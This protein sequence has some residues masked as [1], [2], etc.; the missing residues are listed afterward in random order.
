MQFI[1]LK[2]QYS[3]LKADID[4]R[5]HAVLDHGSYIMGPE[6]TKLE[7]EL[8][9]YV[10]VK[11]CL[12]CANGTDALLLALMAYGVKP[13][14]GIITTPFTF[15]ATAEVIALLGAVPIFVDIDP[16]TYNIN[17]DALQE[18]IT[19]VQSGRNLHNK[20]AFTGEL[21]G[22]IPV[23]LF[24]IPADYAKINSIAKTNGLFVLEDAAQS[25]GAT[26][27]GKKAGLLSEI[28]ATSFFPAKPLGCYGDGGAVFTDNEEIIA[29]MRSLRIHGQGPD[30]YTNIRI[31]INGRMDTIQ[32]AIVLS[33]LSIF[34]IELASRQQVAMRYNQI[35]SAYVETPTVPDGST[36][37][38][39]QYSVQSD[40]RTEVMSALSQQGI[41]TAIYYPTPL[42]LQ[43]AFEYCGYE[44]NSFPVSEKASQRIFSLP[45]HPYLT[46]EEQKHIAKVFA[47]VF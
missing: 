7:S 12:S 16:V 4:S 6:I 21:K 2:R 22:I 8:A 47:A 35:L 45:M 41:P 37:A 33:K 42:H 38:W 13:G 3:I 1:D 43:K 18:T 31:G 17:P 11:Y 20:K 34:D 46:E 14:D 10:G 36:S 15:V 44:K 29:I 40:K 32:A 23:D 24:G 39:A 27:N 28:A 30:K 19:T 26:Y 9:R 25:F 5:I